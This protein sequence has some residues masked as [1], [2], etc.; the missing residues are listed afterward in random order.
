MNSLF[1]ALMRLAGLQ[2]E[3]VDVA[4][5]RGIL[6]ELDE[7]SGGVLNEFAE[8]LNVRAPRWHSNPARAVF[9][10]LVC[11]ALGHWRIL[12]GKNGSGAWVL[13][14]WRPDASAWEEVTI[15]ELSGCRIASLRLARPYDAS[16]SP[17]LDLIRAEFVRNRA[18]LLEAS[19]GG[20]AINVIA[21]TT[22]FYSMQVY[23]RVVPT[24]ASQTLLVLT[25]GVLLA[26]LIELGAKKARS[27]IY[28]HLIDI[29]D[30]KMAHTV[31]SRFL[32]IRLDQLP[33][34][35][36]SL[37]SQM[38]GYETVRAFLSG[39]ATYVIVDAPFVI[40]F[41]VVIFWIAGAL[42]LIPAL[43]AL[44]CLALGFYHIRR[45]E[46]VTQKSSVAA[47]L[48]TGLLV[49]TVEGAE[50]IKSGQANWRMLNRWL[51]VTDDARQNDLELR[52]ISEH[53]QY[54]T[55]F[56]QQIT[57][58]LIVAVGAMAI[59]R[60]ELSMG[61]LIACSILGGRVLAP[62]SAIPGQLLQWGHA[63]AALQGL[64]RLW[65]LQS[66]HHGVEAPV[67]VDE[68]R[69][70]YGIEKAV[71][72]YAGKDALVIPELR[73]QS[74][75]KIGIL[76][77]VGSGKTS[78]LRLLSGMYKPQEGRVFLDGIDMAHLSKP[79]LAERMAYVQQDGRLFAGS[80]RENLILGLMDP[81]DEAIL[82]AARKTG[83]MSAVIS[84]HPKGLQQEI[85]EGGT[86]LSGGQRQLVNLT[87]ALLRSPRIWLLDE[88]TASIDRGHE[89]QVIVAL[90]GA[91]EPEHTLVLVTHKQ[92]MLE[93]V[94][95]II[96]IAQHRVVMDG[97]KLH[98]LQR[99]QAGAHQPIR[100]TGSA[101]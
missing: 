99:L 76:G 96:V 60:G 44:P 17:V 72:R 46:D 9:P 24:G 84:D 22:S 64:D 42:A 40:I 91:I 79:Q 43:F 21:L 101:A 29:I 14:Q 31:Y 7:S 6:S 77:P 90:R 53:S 50:T 85:H 55:A 69:G 33:P 28:E 86:G 70:N 27:R 94:D 38:R 2:R 66:D 57:Y 18:L 51:E 45:I 10:S 93:H 83:L 74:G 67:V 32:A 3:P 95:R 71:L 75:E 47:N 68:I 41:L 82:V 16:S 34:S 36:G 5:I 12:R 97:P 54:G 81:G 89:Q 23:D 30:Q 48:K 59:S 88:P 52:R 37:A 11:D 49:E 62:L 35:V 98:V 8:R 25:L 4:E 58:I 26:L 100:A 61:A 19:I 92:E 87:R 65:M 1:P 63:K 15:P 56:L 20:V 78:L 80:L 39:V 73:I 13:D